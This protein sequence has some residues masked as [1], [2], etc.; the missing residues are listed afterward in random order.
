MAKTR[1]VTYSALVRRRAC[2][3]AITEL[4][5]VCTV[6]ARLHTT[7]PTTTRPSRRPETFP[8]VFACVA[9]FYHLTAKSRYALHACKLIAPG[10]S[11]PA[12]A[13]NGGAQVRVFRNR[14]C[15]SVSSSLAPS[16]LVKSTGIAYR[17]FKHGLGLTCLKYPSK[18]SA[19]SGPKHVS[20][21]LRKV[22]L[23]VLTG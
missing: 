20:I 12:K 19:N 22:F 2:S 5:S 7:L 17:N 6:Y 16:E 13:E 23:I 3:S 8:S 21:L 1:S 11:A 18:I 15:T 4:A 14:P 10:R 9:C